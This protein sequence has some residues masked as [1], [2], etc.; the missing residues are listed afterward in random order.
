M[1]CERHVAGAYRSENPPVVRTQIA[2]I[3]DIQL[4]FDGV[5]VLFRASLGECAVRMNRSRINLEA[6]RKSERAAV[7]IGGS[8][9]LA[10][11]DV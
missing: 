9:G 4:H 8:G 2:D 1:N 5:F 11:A 7:I 6:S 10:P 3:L